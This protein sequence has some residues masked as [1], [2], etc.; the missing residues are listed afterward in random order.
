MSA[1]LR[2]YRAAFSAL[3]VL[4]ALLTACNEPPTSV[5]SE[6][7][8][9]TDTIYA[10]S[11]LSSPMID[12]GTTVSNREPLTNSTY[13]LLGHTPTDDARIFIQFI[14]YPKLGADSSYD[15]LASD[16][17]MFPQDYK[18]GD[19]SDKSVSFD[20][21]E[22]KREWSANV[23]WDSIWAADGST[24]YYSTS[25][26]SV[27]SFSETITTP[28]DT[29][30]YVPF[31]N[32]AVKRW[33]VAGQDSQA[34][35][36]VHGIVLLPRNSS[37]VIRQ[38]RTLRSVTQLMKLRVIRKLRDSAS[39]IDTVFIEA[40]VANF[41]NTPDPQVGEM[42]VQGAR[43]HRASFTVNLDSLPSKG[44]II[45]GTLRITSDIARS[46]G[47]TYGLDEV[48][49]VRYEPP[50]G[51]PIELQ[52]RVDA[53]GV[54]VFSNIGPLMQLIRK[55][56]GKAVLEIKPTGSDEFWRMNRVYI[57]EPSSDASVRPRLTIAYT[58]PGV[59]IK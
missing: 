35:K 12:S 1:S 21:Y 7:V 32:V 2:A 48:L 40:S 43:V 55:Y 42:V 4:C 44:V 36:D 11:S 57:Y 51:S 38:F 22:L 41:V 13:F 37:N 6:I 49:A 10:L 25:D 52:T 47:G 33:L 31:D 15:I 20:T 28:A 30:V 39:T 5:G 46:Q 23:T 27:C 29:V 17:L 3:S 9:G 50:T 26:P 34:V 24:D 16:L 18:Y 56:G 59:F 58:I 19:T 45:G 14:N 8:P 53:N 54:Y